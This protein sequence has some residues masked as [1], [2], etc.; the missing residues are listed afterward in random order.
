MLTD[1]DTPDVLDRLRTANLVPDDDPAP[2]LAPV[3][4]RLDT[5][6][7]PRPWRS[8]PRRFAML[9]GAAAVAAVGVSVVAASGPSRHGGAAPLGVLQVAAARAEANAGATRFSGYVAE[10]VLDLKGVTDRTWKVIRPVSDTEFE[11][12]LEKPHRAPTP[13][14]ERMARELAEANKGRFVQTDGRHT[15]RREGDQIRE[16]YSWQRP[17]GT[18]FNGGL[19][20]G[21]QP[22]R[23][24]TDPTAAA[25]TVAALAAGE[26]P[27]NIEKSYAG[28]LEDAAP[29][30]LGRALNY[31]EDVLTA[32]RVSPDV[33]AAV[34][35]ALS[36]VAGIT[37]DDHAT[38]PA[39]R[40]AAALTAQLDKGPAHTRVELLFDPDSAL[41]LAERVVFTADAGADDHRPK[42]EPPYGEGTQVTTYRYD[43]G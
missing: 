37:V 40:S 28:L 3:L 42:G 11:G 39:G 15:S 27:A 17:Y 29:F 23:V 7:R 30:P 35:R 4:R 24:P 38:D 10:T 5:S 33:R 2:P 1:T 19:A 36:G 8:A 22:A 14:Q 20:P 34:Y 16:I 41:V 25:N 31:A 12:R 32:P 43:E 6:R 18:I 26:M 9:A 21:E 13:E